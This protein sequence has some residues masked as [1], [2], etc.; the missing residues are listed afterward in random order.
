MG[1][2][3]SMLKKIGLIVLGLAAG[4]AVAKALKNAGVNIFA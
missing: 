2:A 1:N 3:K 4:A